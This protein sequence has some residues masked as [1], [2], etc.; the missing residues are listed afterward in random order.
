MKK[1]LTAS[2]L[3]ASLALPS[4][5][6]ADAY[7]D[8]LSQVEQL[9]KKYQKR[10][11][12]YSDATSGW[13]VGADQLKS[14]FT[15]S[16]E[17]RLLWQ[18]IAAEFE[19]QGTE[20]VVLAAP[21][22]PLFV[23]DAALQAIGVPEGFDREA[24]ARAFSD[25]IAALNDAGL[26]A[27]DLSILARD[28]AADDFYFRRDTHWTP[29]GAALS[30]AALNA[31]IAGIPPAAPLDGPSFSADYSEKGSLST[32]VEKVCGSRPAA[33]VVPAPVFASAGDVDA[34]LSEAPAGPGV[35]L[36]GTSFSD[37]YQRDAYQVSG[38]IAH[39]L[40]A[41]V[42]NYSVSGGGL[43]AAMSGFLATGGL[44]EEHYQT[45]VWES[46]YTSPLTQ[47][48]GLR[49]ILG[50]LRVARGAKPVNRISHSIGDEWVSIG[51]AFSTSDHKILEINVPGHTSGTL[52]VELVAPDGEKTRVKLVKSDRLPQ[53]KRNTRWTMALDGLAFEQIGRIKLRLKGQDDAKAN[54][55]FF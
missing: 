4:P 35:A 39:A 5:I 15:V 40:G 27:P 8:T 54:L 19:A 30:A 26:V 21:P 12:F 11:P 28:A 32:V 43:T 34:L 22:R 50:E 55:S 31:A 10:G 44:T 37:R 49:Q 46:P 2:A 7:C 41:E 9:P 14:T 45:V 20:L 17:A 42:R 23:P 18:S 16:D 52:I 38:A 51:H 13:I 25:Y 29:Q 24:M 48:D 33:E 3:A 53:E 47:T 36:V 6:L 1:M